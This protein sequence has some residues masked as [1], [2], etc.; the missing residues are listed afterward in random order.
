LV[1]RDA[2]EGVDYDL[3]ALTAVWRATNDQDGT[4]VARAQKG[5]ANPAYEPGPYSL[6]EGD[7]EAFVNWYIGR[8]QQ[9]LGV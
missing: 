6:V 4:L 1:H 8:L 2:V 9:H 5:V 3:D 7:V